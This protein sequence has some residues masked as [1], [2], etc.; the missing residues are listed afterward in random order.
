[1]AFKMKGNPFQRNF[2]SGSP[3]NQG[4]AETREAI[5]GTVTA[6]STNAELRELAKKSND[7]PDG[8]SRSGQYNVSY[9]ELL[10]LRRSFISRRGNEPKATEYGAKPVTKPVEKVVEEPVEEVVEEKTSDDRG[11]ITGGTDEWF[12][13]GVTS[14]DEMHKSGVSMNE[15]LDANYNIRNSDFDNPEELARKNKLRVATG[16]DAIT[17]RDYVEQI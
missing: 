11:G 10:K 15:W 4:T 1:M 5:L 12:H 8:V 9:P 2:N 16:D 3:L 13:R 14:S 7:G 6:D 17:S